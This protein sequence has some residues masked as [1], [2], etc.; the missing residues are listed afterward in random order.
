MDGS[1]LEIL[2]AGA[3]A[4]LGVFL[5]SSGVQGWAL[6]QRAAWFLRVGLIVGALFL[7]EGGLAS[8]LIGLVLAVA[9]LGAQKVLRPDPDIAF[10]VRGAD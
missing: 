8:D 4:T 9:S 1:W 10:D 2:R 7:I 5:L 3:T 6:G